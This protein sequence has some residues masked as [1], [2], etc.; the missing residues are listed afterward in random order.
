MVS[1]RDRLTTSA[2]KQCFEKVGPLSLEIHSIQSRCVP[3]KEVGG[4]G[5]DHPTASFERTSPGSTSRLS[6][7]G[8]RMRRDTHRSQEPT[9]NEP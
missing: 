2:S 6:F 5:I 7:T 9:G 4:G 8:S 3:E 1:F